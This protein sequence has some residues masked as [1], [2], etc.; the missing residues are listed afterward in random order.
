MFLSEKEF[1]FHYESGEYTLHRSA[2]RMHVQISSKKKP[3]NS[4]ILERY[5]E[6]TL[7]YYRRSEK[8]E[9]RVRK[10]NCDIRFLKKDFYSTMNPVNILFI[11]L[12]AVCMF[13][14]PQKKNLSTV[15]Y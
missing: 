5:G 3:F 8:F 7:R 1:L 6:E 14:F 15:L 4:V 9:K 2:C 12:H 10:I 11:A 13:R